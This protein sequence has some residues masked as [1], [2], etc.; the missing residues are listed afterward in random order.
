MPCPVLLLLLP[1]QPLTAEQY[2]PCLGSTL[3]QGLRRLLPRNVVP[4][5]EPKIELAIVPHEEAPALI[6]YL[7]QDELGYVRL[8][9]LPR[10]EVRATVAV[11]EDAKTTICR[12]A[13]SSSPPT[14][15]STGRPCDD[16]ID[17]KTKLSNAGIAAKAR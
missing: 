1:K 14:H 8:V 6:A 16:I 13:R 4:Y 17:Y 9:V 10:V 7:P 12:G 11:D 3:S 2:L 15:G 5:L